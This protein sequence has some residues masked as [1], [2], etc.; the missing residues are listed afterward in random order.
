VLG[1]I[2]QGSQVR[3]VLVAAWPGEARHVVA[4]GSAPS[5]RWDALGPAY[6]ESFDTMRLDPGTA[7]PSTR[8]RWA[9]AA[10]VASLLMV[11]VGLW[12]R[13]QVARAA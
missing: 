6:G 9:F 13:R 12:R 11:S 5:G 7:G 8:L 4:I 10:L 2:R 1:S 3:R